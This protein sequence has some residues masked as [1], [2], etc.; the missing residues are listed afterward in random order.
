MVDMSTSTYPFKCYLETLLSYNADAKNTHLETSFFYK[1]KP[2]T[3]AYSK[4]SQGEG[5]YKDRSLKVKNGKNYIFPH[6]FM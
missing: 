5:G 6:K 4:L 3:E 1:E 2:G